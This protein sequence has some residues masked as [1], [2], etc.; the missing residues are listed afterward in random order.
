MVHNSLDF[1]IFC[2]RS[3]RFGYFFQDFLYLV[4]DFEQP[5]NSLK[6]IDLLY[7]IHHLEP[8]NSLENKRGR[9]ERQWKK[10]VKEEK[11]KNDKREGQTWNI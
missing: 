2:T 10:I 6:K 4:H 1:A 5:N 8:N 11:K 9:E 3:F 7:L